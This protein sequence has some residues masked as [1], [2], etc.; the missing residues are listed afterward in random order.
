MLAD[1]NVY[2]WHRDTGVLLEVLEGHGPG[3]VNSVAWNPCNRRMF[4][5]CSDDHTIRVWEAPVS[6]S[7]L[8]RGLSIPES[9]VEII[10]KGKGKIR[11][12][13]SHNDRT[14]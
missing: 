10:G 14:L 11:Q 13:W 9:E 6:S 1:R 4:A 7:E 3:S 5:S 12:P 8:Y 2:V